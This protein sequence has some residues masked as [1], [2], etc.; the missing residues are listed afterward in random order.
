MAIKFWL[1][2]EAGKVLPLFTTMPPARFQR[3]T[4]MEAV[5]H[6]LLRVATGSDGLTTRSIFLADSTSSLQKATSGIRSPG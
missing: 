2:R 4:E 6:P 1:H 3:P 5:T